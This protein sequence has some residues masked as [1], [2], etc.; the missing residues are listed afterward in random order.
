MSDF[1]HRSEPGP[2]ESRRAAPDV[3]DRSLPAAG[4]LVLGLLLFGAPDAIPALTVPGTG[5]MD[6]E[7]GTVS[8]MGS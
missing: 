8:P 7:M 1:S 4:L 6:T 3:I 2:A 5:Q